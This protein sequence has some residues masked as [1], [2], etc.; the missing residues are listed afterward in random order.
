MQS[1]IASKM[2]DPPEKPPDK[3]PEE[4]TFQKYE[5]NAS[6]AAPYRIIVQRVGDN[7]DTNETR[8][9]KL[10]VGRLLSNVPTL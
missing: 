2:G 9:N 7:D 3:T 10:S 6:D 1:Y 4:R 5:Y 8:I